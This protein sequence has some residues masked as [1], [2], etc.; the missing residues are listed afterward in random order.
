MSVNLKS[1]FFSQKFKVSRNCRI[2]WY[3]KL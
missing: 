2:I 1:I 3:W